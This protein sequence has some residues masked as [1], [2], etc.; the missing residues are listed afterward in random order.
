[1][2][3]NVATMFVLAGLITLI[4]R[5]YFTSVQNNDF[6]SSKQYKP[7]PKPEAT[8][9]NKTKKSFSSDASDSFDG[10]ADFFETS[11]SNT[12]NHSGG[13]EDAFSDN[14]S[15]FGGFD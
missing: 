11:G 5:W 2:I 7:K 13:F 15:D 10:F 9:T 8:K 3:S 4:L 12:T 14:G 6:N 1:M